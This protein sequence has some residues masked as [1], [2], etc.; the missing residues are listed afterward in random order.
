[1]KKILFTILF[2]SLFLVMNRDSSI[3]LAKQNDLGAI[4]PEAALEYMKNT[5]DLVIIDTA[6]LE[7]HE[8]EHFI[9]SMHIYAHDLPKLFDSIPK[10]RPVI[11]HC[12]LGMIVTTA[13]GHIKELRPDI[14]E[15]SYIDGAP[16]FNEYNDWKI[17]ND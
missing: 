2:Y 6:A 16:L 11:L 8:R 9:G 3:L 1:M 4:K 5:K 15:I 12:R 17:S 14:P 7:Y 13:Y 10:N